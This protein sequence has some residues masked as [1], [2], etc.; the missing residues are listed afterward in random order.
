VEG[1]EVIEY[2]PV[3]DNRNNSIP[4]ERITSRNVNDAIQRCITKAIARHGLGLYIYAGEDLP[5][6]DTTKARD[7]TARKWICYD[8]GRTIEDASFPDG[9]NYTADQ[10]AGGSYKRYKVT[11][12]ANCYTARRANDGNESN[13]D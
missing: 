6:D 12:C 4:L 9:K 10:I 8:C 7:D 5:E 1:Q 2:L 13:G 11:L 3:M